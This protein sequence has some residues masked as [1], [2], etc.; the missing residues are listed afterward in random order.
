[1]FQ[2]LSTVELRHDFDRPKQSYNI[3]L[4]DRLEKTKNTLYSTN[5][6]N[7]YLEENNIKPAQFLAG[8]HDVTILANEQNF[9]DILS[10]YLSSV[11]ADTSKD[12]I[13]FFKQNYILDLKLKSLS[14][15]RFS[16]NDTDLSSVIQAIQSSSVSQCRMQID[17]DQLPFLFLVAN[18]LLDKRGHEVLMRHVKFFCWNLLI[19]EFEIFIKDACID[20]YSRHQ[21]ITKEQEQLITDPLI[22]HQLKFTDNIDEYINHFKSVFPEKE[23]KALVHRYF[24]G[25]RDQFYIESYDEPIELIYSGE[26]EKLLLRDLAGPFKVV[27]ATDEL[28]DQHVTTLLSYVYHCYRTN[29]I[30]ELERFKVAI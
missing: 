27:Y 10:C 22:R 19:G 2:L 8:M 5:G 16:K 9:S 28:W 4:S 6:L 23:A 3:I 21:V 12:N 7:S 30:K 26:Y 17:Y 25:T 11:L 15:G 14:K 18:W 29:N 20:Y 13:D 24:K 1:M